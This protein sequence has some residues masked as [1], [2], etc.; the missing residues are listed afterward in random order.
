MLSASL[1][2]PFP[3][4]NVSSSYNMYGKTKHFDLPF[5]K[6]SHQHIGVMFHNILF[7]ILI[8]NIY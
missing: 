8:S 6:T 5:Q 7:K 1:N 4:F 3:S 2:K